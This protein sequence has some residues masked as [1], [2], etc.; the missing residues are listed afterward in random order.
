MTENDKPGVDDAENA[1][2][3]KKKSFFTR[4]KES[5]MG[6]EEDLAAAEGFIADEEIAPWQHIE[7]SPEEQAS[8]LSRI[9][10]GE[11][12]D[13]ASE[14]EAD[15]G[16]TAPLV[17][18]LSAVPA[19]FHAEGGATA[20][21]SSESGSLSLASSGDPL[22]AQSRDAFEQSRLLG[23]LQL[24]TLLGERLASHAALPPAR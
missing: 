21:G 11:I 20:S 22:A 19:L 15:R 24:R 13:F 16:P 23:E 1:S 6:S 10:S 4:F 8:L 18:P 17:T 2:A 12:V 5:F 9:S 7:L 14:A 3:P